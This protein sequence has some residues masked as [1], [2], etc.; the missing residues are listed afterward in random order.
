VRR[1]KWLRKALQNLQQ[2][3]D[4]IAEDDPDAAAKVILKMQAGVNQ[5]EEFPMLGYVGRV[6]GTR[7]L[8][9][10]NTPYVVIYRVKGN[11][12]QILRVL[13]HSKRYPN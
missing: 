10:A 6:Q 4:Y 2:A 3:Y 8:V 13:H 12:V 1:V 11:M 7:E 9:M 5:L